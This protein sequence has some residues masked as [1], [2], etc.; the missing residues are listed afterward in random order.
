MSV[1]GAGKLAAGPDAEASPGLSLCLQLAATSGRR[2]HGHTWLGHT[3]TLSL[4][5]ISRGRFGC[6]LQ[7]TLSSCRYQRMMEA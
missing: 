5:F 4:Q 2:V 3:G 7:A 6:Q 1:R